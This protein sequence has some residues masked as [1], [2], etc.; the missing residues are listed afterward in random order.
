MGQR[1]GF[2]GLGLMGAPMARRLLRAD[3]S[4]TVWNR[5][6][7]RT[8][9]IAREG[10]KIANSP[11]HLA[12]MVDIVITVV[13]GP[14]ALK[15]ILIGEDG[16]ISAA[17]PGTILVDMS[18]V[19]IKTTRDI[20]EKATAA[21][22]FMLDA[23]VTGS[24]PG[25][26][27]GTLTL[28]IGGDRSTFDKVYP[29]LQVFGN[30]QY[31][32]PAGMGA[33]VKLSQNLI[34]AAIAQALAEG[35]RLAEIHGLKIEIVQRILEFT[36]VNSKFLQLKLDKMA[37]DDYSAQFSLSNMAKDLA[38]VK[39]AAGSGGVSLPLA[40]QLSDIYNNAVKNGWGEADYAA[41]LEALR[42]TI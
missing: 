33:L 35:V 11:A 30:P 18:T 5:T 3:Y 13:T 42:Q 40:N 29:I 37:R 39:E 15:E 31:V 24:V 25:A 26:E 14:N 8:E 41:L 12:G 38:L 32:G 9:S 6:A 22:L 19:G 4:L 28:M 2:I 10:A 36:G 34:A 27:N 16:V 1:I 20:R 21:G 7:T 17:K 23:P